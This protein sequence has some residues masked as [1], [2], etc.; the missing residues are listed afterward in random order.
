MLMLVQ[1]IFDTG[2]GCAMQ[3]ESECGNVWKLESHTVVYIVLP[4]TTAVSSVWR[5]VAPFVLTLRESTR[6]CA[7][8]DCMKTTDKRALEQLVNWYQ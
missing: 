8:R 6:R 7:Y 1:P 5:R 4:S 3:A 2:E